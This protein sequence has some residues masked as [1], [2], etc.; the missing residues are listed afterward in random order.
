M[1][2]PILSTLVN[3]EEVYMPDVLG[4]Y[5]SDALKLLNKNKFNVSVKMIDYSKGCIPFTVHDIYPKPYTK[6]K[7]GRNV[8]L[9]VFSDR[10]KIKM[11][12][13]IGLD[14]R[15]AKNSI[16]LDRLS[17]DE[18]DIFYYFDEQDSIGHVSRQLPEKGEHVI[19]GDSVSLWV[20]NGRPPNEYVIPDVV[21]KSLKYA[22]GELKKRGFLVGEIKKIDN[23]D[24]LEDTVYELSYISANGYNIEV[25]EGIKYTAPIKIDITVTKYGE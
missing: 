19:E 7:K 18:R 20:C 8:E 17:I 24:F 16:R 25:I 11:P 2:N 1:F 13:Y 5:K 23:N 22:I 9:V 3:I 21:G 12:S 14:I 4:E 15:E 10:R 6:V